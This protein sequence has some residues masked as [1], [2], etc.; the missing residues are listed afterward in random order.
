M[1]F[2]HGKYGR[3]FEHCGQDTRVATLVALM[4]SAHGSNLSI[5]MTATVPASVNEKTLD[6]SMARKKA[7]GRS[8]EDTTKEGMTMNNE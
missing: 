7:G 5:S 6:D 1:L 3:S 2:F 8:Q 4:C